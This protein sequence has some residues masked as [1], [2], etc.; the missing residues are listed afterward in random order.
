MKCVTVLFDDEQIY[1]DVK[2]QAARDGR[3]A[4]DVVAEALREW[5]RRPGRI[6]EEERSQRLHALK[7]LD[8][9]RA[10]LKG[11]KIS[12]TVEEALEAM[13]NEHP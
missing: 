8:K 12:E 3:P 7:E 10:E 11:W 9:P 5:L 13:R 4:K 1:R 2:A 6:S